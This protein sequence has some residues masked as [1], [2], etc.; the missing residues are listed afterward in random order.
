MPPT[1]AAVGV[2]EASKEEVLVLMLVFVM[3]IVLVAG[4]DGAVHAG[5]RQAS[6]ATGTAAS[7]T[8]KVCPNIVTTRYVRFEA[9]NWAFGSCGLL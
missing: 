7:V 2:A 9:A 1:Q 5:R 6:S 3:I 4:G 8:F